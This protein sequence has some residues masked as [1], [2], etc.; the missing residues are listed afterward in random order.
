MW[1]PHQ[2]TARL[3]RQGAVLEEQAPATPPSFFHG[4]WQKFHPEESRRRT[5]P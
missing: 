5:L 1:D 3:K 4:L 2:V